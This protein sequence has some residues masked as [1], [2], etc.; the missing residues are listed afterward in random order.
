MCHTYEKYQ[1][2]TGVEL[3]IKRLSLVALIYQPYFNP[4][5]KSYVVYGWTICQN[6]SY[7]HNYRLDWIIP[8]KPKKNK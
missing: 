4:T 7:F 1:I 3:A 8:T 2:C 5:N 6:Q